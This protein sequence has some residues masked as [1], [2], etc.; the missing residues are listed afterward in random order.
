MSAAEHRRK[1]STRQ[2]RGDGNVLLERLSRTEFDRIAGD[3]EPVSLQFKETLYE[4][5]ERIKHVYF[6]TGSVVSI[7]TALD[8]GEEPVETSTIGRE[9]LVGLPV[10]LES[11][12]AQARAICQVA[13]DALRMS[14]DR[15]AAAVRRSDTLRVQLLRYTNVLMAM[16]AQTAA[17]NRAHDTKVR[18]AR[19]LL[20]TQDRVGSRDFTLT[21]EFLGQMLGV[22]RPA[23]SIAGSSLQRDGLIKY[24]RGRITVVDR[25]GLEAV[26]CDCYA[27]IHQ[28]FVR[29]FGSEAGLV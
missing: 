3:L 11:S 24:T 12:S 4:R 23:V 6:P 7:I 22:R 15:F 18:M 14:V 20:M 16:T 1:R 27:Y 21:Q 19:W 5:D 29:H 10:F 28:Q 13:G 2:D 9:G 26:S 17:C 25:R 8:A